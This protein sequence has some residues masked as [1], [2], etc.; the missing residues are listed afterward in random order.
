VVQNPPAPHTHKKKFIIIF[1]LWDW[2]L[3]SEFHACKTGSLLFELYLQ[4]ILFWLFWRWGLLNY[5]PRLALNQFLLIS[6]S[7]V[8]RITFGSHWCHWLNFILCIFYVYL[9]KTVLNSHCYLWL[10]SNITWLILAS[11]FICNFVL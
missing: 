1:F 8:A 6:A 7:Q 4:T 11:P 9:T 10:Q 2:G 5:L 3:N